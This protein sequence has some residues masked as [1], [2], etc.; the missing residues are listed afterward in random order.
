MI[1]L[2]ENQLPGEML[3]AVREWIGNKASLMAVEVSMPI[4]GC[5]LITVSNLKQWVTRVIHEK[6]TLLADNELKDFMSIV[7]DRTFACFKIYDDELNQ[8]SGKVLFV[9]L[10]ACH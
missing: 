7:K 3:S 8:N 9:N 2:Y 5:N 1:D 10:V 6:I 4:D